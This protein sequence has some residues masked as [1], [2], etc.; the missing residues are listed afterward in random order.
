MEKKD[1]ITYVGFALAV[2]ASATGVFGWVPAEIAWGI[3][4]LFGFGTL[5]AARTF[6]E[7]KGWK[8]YVIDIPT[9]ILGVATALGWVTLEIYAQVMVVIGMLNVG[10]LAHADKKALETG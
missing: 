2:F 8:T 1:I 10:T 9:A 3:A 4:G 6:I 7:S 5:A